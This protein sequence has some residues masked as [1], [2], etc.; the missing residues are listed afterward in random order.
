MTSPTAP[1]ALMPTP[2]PPALSS[3]EILQSLWHLAG[4]P[5][6]ALA[7]AQLPGQSPVLPSSFNLAG[8]AQASLAATALAALQVGQLRGA[9][10]RSFT[11]DRTGALL[12]CSAHLRVDGVVANPWDKLSGLYPCGQALGRPGWVRLHANFAHHRDGALRLLGLPEGEATPREAVAQALQH[13]DAEGLEA[14]AADAGLVVAALRSPADWRAHA[15]GIHEAALPVLRWR[16][17]GDAPA[18]AWPALPVGA[19]PLQGLRVLDLTR[20]LAGPCAGQLLAVHGAEVAMVNSPNLPNIAHIADFSRGKRSMLLDLQQDAGR[21]ALGQLVQGAHV[22]LQGYRPGGLAAHGFSP[23]ELAQRRPGIVVASLSAYSA[24]GPWAGKRGF[25]SLVQT[26]TGMNLDE[27]SALGSDAPK[28]L[29]VQMLDYAAGRLL[30]FGITVALLRQATQGGSWLV[31]VSLAGAGHWL[32]SLGRVADGAGVVAPAIE[33]WLED[34]PSDWGRLSTVRHAVAIDGLALPP[35]GPAHR[36]GH[37][38][39]H[40]G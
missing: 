25:D 18:L 34:T 35:L 20:I 22:F 2:L 13:W 29:P 32:R 16:R 33:P 15:Q 1:D 17:L 31:E 37:D 10:A 38:A 12:G 6:A 5:E 30:A 14:L 23:A 8:A 39:P 28:A 19:P 24:G 40:W 4:L 27:A 9:P 7:S 11:V 26:A 36:P 3:A 21:D